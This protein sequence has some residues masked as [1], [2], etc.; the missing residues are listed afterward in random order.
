MIEVVLTWFIGISISNYSLNII[1][2]V[3]TQESTSCI[4]IELTILFSTSI[5]STCEYVLHLLRQNVYN[6]KHSYLLLGP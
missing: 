3:G 4:D 2:V 1:T 5:I 6:P